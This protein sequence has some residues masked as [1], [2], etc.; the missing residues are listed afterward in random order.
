MDKATGFWFN[1]VSHAYIPLKKAGWEIDIVSPAGGLCP[2]EPS[3]LAENHMDKED[4]ALYTD[5]T[6][7]SQI[8]NSKKPS[9]VDPKNY[10]L[11]YYAGG[12][13]T[14]YDFYDEG[15]LHKIAAK[16]Y[17]KGGVVAAI[18]HGPV[19]IINIKL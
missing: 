18:C 5:S 14:V 6:F 9:D 7:R 12:H 15:E 16:I 10:D 19:G 4:W 1:E 3:S 2:V 13:G 11:I 17:E 8:G